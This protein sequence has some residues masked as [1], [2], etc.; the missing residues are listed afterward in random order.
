MSGYLQRLLSSARGAESSVQP[1]VRRVYSPSA[2]ASPEQPAPSPLLTER[3][4]GQQSL[5]EREWAQQSRPTVEIAP[6]QQLRNSISPRQ[7][8]DLADEA[9]SPA[10]PVHLADFV[11]LLP[12]EELNTSQPVRAPGARPEAASPAQQNSTGSRHAAHMRVPAGPA[13]ADVQPVNATL[14]PP[15]ETAPLQAPKYADTTVTP[16]TRPPSLVAA[17]A[18]SAHDEIQIHIGRIEVT[19]MPPPARPAA[20]KPANNGPSLQEY[21]KRRDRSVQ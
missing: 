2:A 14:S 12:S 10:P 13:S 19:A 8:N 4:S 15:V 7:G 9:H 6:A 20:Q 16:P 5:T 3:E 18:A 17:A 21:L 11:P 1:L